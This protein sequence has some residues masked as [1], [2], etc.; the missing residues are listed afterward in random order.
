MQI[1]MWVISWA[2]HMSK[3]SIYCI[4]ITVVFI[5]QG[6]LTALGLL[7][8]EEAEL[9]HS[10]SK[11]NGEHLRTDLSVSDLISLK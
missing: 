10:F 1:A 6:Y 9:G 4:L 8:F 2:I 5:L 11:A 7:V 3:L